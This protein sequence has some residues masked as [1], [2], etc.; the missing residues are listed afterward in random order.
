[1]D[2][3]WDPATGQ[4]ICSNDLNEL[5]AAAGAT[6]PA[7]THYMPEKWTRNGDMLAVKL[8]DSNV[9]EALID[10]FYT[11]DKQEATSRICTF[12]SRMQNK[13]MRVRV[14]CGAMDAVACLNFHNNSLYDT[15]FMHR[16]LSNAYNV[17]PGI[18]VYSAEQMAEWALR[19]ATTFLGVATNERLCKSLTDLGERR[20]MAAGGVGD[21]EIPPTPL[22]PWLFTCQAA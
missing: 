3:A 21:Q 15:A 12:L 7:A 6:A 18:V 8:T 19:V 4:T 2:G 5:L 14:E 10:E 13:H 20:R 11:L 17:Q 16:G 1:M 22:T 9:N